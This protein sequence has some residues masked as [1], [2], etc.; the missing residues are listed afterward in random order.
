MK[1][2]IKIKSALIY[3][4]CIAGTTVLL[5]SCS[6]NK[7]RDSNEIAKEENV[8]KLAANDTT[9]RVIK[10]DNDSRFL[11]KAAEIQMEMISLG[12]LA[13]QKGTSSHVKELGKMMVEDHTKSHNEIKALAQSKSVSIP[14]TITDNS[15][16]FHNDLNEKTGNDFGKSYSKRMVDRLE[17]AIDSYENAAEDSED[18]QVRAYASEKLT[19]LRAH[20]KHAEDCKEKCDN[21]KS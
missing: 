13:Q 11:E 20:L 5:S 3:F 8:R 1:N 4:L 15:R 19:S 17:D 7:T 10:D 14:T 16:D 18:P 9:A 6:E 12:Q 21:M 2:F